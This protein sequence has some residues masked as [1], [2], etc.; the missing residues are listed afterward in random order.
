MEGDM[1]ND[2]EIVWIGL[3]CLLPFRR[4]F[5]GPDG[6]IGI[7]LSVVV[8]FCYSLVVVKR[9]SVLGPLLILNTAIC[10]LLFSVFYPFVTP[11]ET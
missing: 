2:V 1:L 10:S 9:S 5:L 11:L 4:L 7:A 6:E 3:T 8:K